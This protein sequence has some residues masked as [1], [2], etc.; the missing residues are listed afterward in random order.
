LEL[1]NSVYLLEKIKI[2][3]NQNGRFVEFKLF[4]TSPKT[5]SRPPYFLMSDLIYSFIIC[6]FLYPRSS[7]FFFFS[8]K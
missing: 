4:F 7:P 1:V 5:E 3:W 8:C 6:T 2:I